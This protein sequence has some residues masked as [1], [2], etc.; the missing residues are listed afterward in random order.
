MKEIK[1]NIKKQRMG[2]NNIHINL[3]IRCIQYII[4]FSPKIQMDI[5]T[6]PQMDQIANEFTRHFLLLFNTIVCMNM[7][8]IVQQ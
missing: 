3:A 5:T 6:G 8:S 2:D 7:P 1:V 4:D